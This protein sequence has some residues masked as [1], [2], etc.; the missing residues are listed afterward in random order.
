M[1]VLQQFLEQLAN[2]IEAERF[3][4]MSLGNYKGQEVDLKN[5]Y[6]KP[7]LIKRE[8]KFSFVY[9][10]ERRDVTKNYTV[11]EALA[12]VQGM[13]SVQGFRTAHLSTLNGNFICEC[14]KNGQWIVRTEKSTVAKVASLS[15]DKVK[16]RKLSSAG[17]PYLHELQLTDANG[18]VYKNAQDKWKQ[19]NHYIEILSSVLGE[20]PPKD[21]L[22]VVDMGSGKG[23]LTFAL[24]DYL[25]NELRKPAFVQG[26]EYRKDMVDLCND[27][28]ARSA[29]DK[30][31][32]VEGGIEDFESADKIDVLIALHACD[33]A[34]DEAIFKGISYDADLIVTAPCCHKQIRRELEKQKAEND[35]DFMTKH[36]IFL[37]RHAEMLTDSVRSL[38]LEYA[39]YKTKA[40]QFVSDAHTPK[41]VMIIAVK[42]KVTPEKQ[43]EIRTKLHQ[44]KSYFGIGYHHLERLLGL[45][46]VDMT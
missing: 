24:Y 44:I 4:K 14:K 36:G 27:V 23:Y 42:A 43:S 30:L 8:L 40:I 11:E 21:E 20:L 3:V 5:I 32:F 18:K 9:R 25:N 16:D 22:R 31:N 37:E 29:M 33:I 2:D 45:D 19:I 6:I 34:T 7:V 46:S 35:L 1:A 41:N 13:L 28:A 15:H 39:G 26:V 38:L 17:K 12:L 10:Y